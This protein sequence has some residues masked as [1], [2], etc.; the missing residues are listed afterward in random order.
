MS[1][2][3]VLNAILNAYDE[4]LDKT[5]VKIY[6]CTLGWHNQNDEV[7]QIY[8][9]F[10]KSLKLLVNITNQIQRTGSIKLL[11]KSVDIIAS[12]SDLLR[13]KSNHSLI[14]DSLKDFNEC[15]ICMEVSDCL[16]DGDEDYIVILPCGHMICEHCHNKTPNNLCPMCRH[17]HKIYFC[18]RKPEISIMMDDLAKCD[19]IEKEKILNLIE[20]QKKFDKPICVTKRYGTYDDEDPR[21]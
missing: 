5:T 1:S 14:N 15:P 12:Y 8:S 3:K 20:N 9:D 21:D 4:R 13:V 10:D 19:D 11:Q 18:I 16:K 2:L 6:G 7:K 17:E